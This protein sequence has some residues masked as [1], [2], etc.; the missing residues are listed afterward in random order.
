VRQAIYEGVLPQL[1]RHAADRHSPQP[2]TGVH[3]HQWG[4]SSAAP[5]PRHGATLTERFALTA[6]ADFLSSPPGSFRCPLV[7]ELCRKSALCKHSSGLLRR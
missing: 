5:I 2:E 6:N 7:G 3:Q 1:C 4:V